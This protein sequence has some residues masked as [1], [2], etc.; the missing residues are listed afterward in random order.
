VADLQSPPSTPAASQGG[1]AD[2]PFL[3]HLASA[4]EMVSA[5][6]F[7]EA[8]VEVLQALS[9]APADLRALKLLALVRFKLGR[10]DE[11]R[12]LCHEIAASVPGDAGIHLK[13]GLIALKLDRLDEAVFEL[14]TAARLA[15]DD[16]RAWS[17]LGFVHARRGERSRAAAAFRR[18]GQDELALETE[19]QRGPEGPPLA[20]SVAGSG[21]APEAVP[22]P[23]ASESAG[24]GPARGDGGG[25][26]DAGSGPR[27]RTSKASGGAP[28]ASGSGSG[29]A[30]KSAPSAALGSAADHPFA[31]STSAP[32]ER[33]PRHDSGRFWAAPEEVVSSAP[34]TMRASALV[35]F[36]VSG[37]GPP[38]D[39]PAW[40]GVAVRLAITDGAFV[41]TDAVVACSGVVRWEEAQRRLHGR[42]SG[43][44]LG[45][46]DAPFC[47]VRGRAG[48][49][50]VS[51]PE[52]AGRLVPLLLED[53]VLYLRE[54]CVVA[55]EGTVSWE[56]GHIPRAP[57]GM[58]QFRG[59]GLVVIC[60]RGEPGSVKVKPERPVQAAARHLLGWV[61][62]VVAHGGHLDVG[63]TTAPGAVP[64]PL[65]ITC[66]GEGVVLFEVERSDARSS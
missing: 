16:L 2:D 35:G 64:G 8:E 63:G 29:R 18:A 40:I 65:L 32:P 30:L 10:L 6:L 52:G 1:G 44:R 5:R 23:V 66:E 12:S 26:N 48:E 51:A 56:Y 53:D 17:Y 31:P 9:I 34:G 19:N 61:G 22:A 37:L 57:F 21:I 41:R 54:E 43:D 24:S 59:R 39:Q 60:V 50:F 36:A 20:T 13:L 14:E 7:R 25:A 58:L 47:R 15:P 38:S 49:L 3:D 46:T 27:G 55:F 28:S 4:A 11:S 45:G 42:P 62:R 33:E